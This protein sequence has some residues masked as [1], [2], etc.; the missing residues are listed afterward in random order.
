[1]CTNRLFS[2]GGMIG[3]LEQAAELF[4]E[5]LTYCNHIHT[6]IHTYKCTYDYTVYVHL[7]VVTQ[8]RVLCLICTAEG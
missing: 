8:A 1:M 5:V 7:I 6:Y 4:R 2:E 3:L